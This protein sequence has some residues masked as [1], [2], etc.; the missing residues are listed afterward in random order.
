MM[1]RQVKK[2]PRNLTWVFQEGVPDAGAPAVLERVPLDLVRRRRRPEDEAGREALPG[3][4]A[5]VAGHA[6]RAER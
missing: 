3:E 6:V 4:V 2:I 1:R 5:V